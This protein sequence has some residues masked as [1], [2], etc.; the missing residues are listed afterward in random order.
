MENG[1]FQNPSE[2][3]EMGG[4]NTL[5]Q[6][7]LRSDP[8]WHDQA[9]GHRLTFKRNNEGA[10]ALLQWL[11]TA[12]AATLPPLQVQGAQLCVPGTWSLLQTQQPQLHGKRQLHE[13]TDRNPWIFSKTEVKAKSKIRGD[14]GYKFLLP[15][16]AKHVTA[17]FF[18][19]PTLPSWGLEEFSWFL[20]LFLKE[21]GFF[22]SQTLHVYGE[23]AENTEKTKTILRRKHEPTL[24]NLLI[25][26]FQ[27]FHSVYSIVIL[28][29]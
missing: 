24:L 6:F 22:V 29:F 27:L 15:G 5:R 17:C 11:Q 1:S 16:I 9:P 3:S 14:L 18:T 4:V 10:G 19:L 28:L 21:L 13:N 25:Q 8:K 26:S 12:P 2:H 7:P 20:F 23:H